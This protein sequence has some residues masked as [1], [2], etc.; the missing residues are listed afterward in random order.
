M[1]S[2]FLR[3]VGTEESPGSRD[4]GGHG[5]EADSHRPGG[6]WGI[7]PPAPGLGLLAPRDL[8]IH[9]RFREDWLGCS[10]R[11][12]D[13]AVLYDNAPGTP[14]E[15]SGGLRES[16]PVCRGGGAEVS[17]NSPQ[18][19]LGAGLSG[20]HHSETLCHFSECAEVWDKQTKT[21]LAF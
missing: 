4:R 7:W 1:T 16:H 9:F 14:R 18:G 8:K 21:N 5:E 13:L 17:S 11:N 12:R 6:A 19:D 20:S 10:V 15:P 3:H 2:A